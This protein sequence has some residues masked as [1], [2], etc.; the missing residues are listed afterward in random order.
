MR[1]VAEGL[2]CGTKLPVNDANQMSA[3]KVGEV[4]TIG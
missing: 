2:L 1:G 4:S 3:S